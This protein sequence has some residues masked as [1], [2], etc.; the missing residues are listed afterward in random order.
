MNVPP[1]KNFKSK[2]E[3]VIDQRFDNGRELTKQDIYH[4]AHISKEF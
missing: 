4:T 1:I 3:T 2:E